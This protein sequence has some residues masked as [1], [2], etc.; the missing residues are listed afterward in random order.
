MW[1]C[2]NII[3]ANL[4]G[5]NREFFFSHTLPPPCCLPQDP[6]LTPVTPHVHPPC[7]LSPSKYL[8]QGQPQKFCRHFH[9][10]NVSP[11]LP[12]LGTH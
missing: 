7:V 3:L 1:L 2:L 4:K 10:Q 9:P 11:T 5:D 6:T 8:T 12:A